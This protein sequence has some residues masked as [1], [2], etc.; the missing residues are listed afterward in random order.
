MVIPMIN[1]QK[2]VYAGNLI[3]PEKQESAFP[4]L[5][6]DKGGDST[7]NF[8]GAAVHAPAMPTLV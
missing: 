8:T 5:L 3:K 7:Q 4:S 6:K 1:L 2:E